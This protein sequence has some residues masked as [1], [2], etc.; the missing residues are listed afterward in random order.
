MLQA[1]LLRHVLPGAV[2]TH[3]FEKSEDSVTV[4]SGVNLPSA[5]PAPIECQTA[6]DNMSRFLVKIDKKGSKNAGR[7]KGAAADARAAFQ[8][9]IAESQAYPALNR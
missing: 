7:V 4:G 2:K 6:R 8:P 9:A 1:A 5:F 3:W